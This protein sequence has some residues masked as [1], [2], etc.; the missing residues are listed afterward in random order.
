MNTYQILKNGTAITGALTYNEG[1][2]K[3]RDM[4]RADGENARAYTLEIWMPQRPVVSPA[5]VPAPVEVDEDVARQEALASFL[6]IEIED[7]EDLADYVEESAYP[8]YGGFF[9]LTAEG[10]DYLVLTDAEADEAAT[11]Y[12]RETLWAF[13]ADFL[14]SNTGLPEEVFTA[15]QDKCEDANETFL[16]LVNKCGD[17]ERLVRDAI[18]SDGR[19]H[20]LSPYDGAEN[21]SGD[22]F[23]YRTN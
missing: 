1:M 19:G 21:E 18:A 12:I 7:G 17:F 22:Y 13:N 4:R 14:A 8:T 3:L 23:I 10:R 2:C 15:M 6:E 9:E 11:D 20:F 16:T 5:D